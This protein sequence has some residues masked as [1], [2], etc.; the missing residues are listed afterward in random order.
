MVLLL[1]LLGR[2]GPFSIDMYLPG[3]PSIAGDFS[4]A[5]ADVQ[6]SL[7][8]FLVGF[9][10]APLIYGPLS[11]RFGRRPI[12]ITA[13]TVYFLSTVCCALTSTMDNFLA[14]RVLQGIGAGAGPV[15]SRAIVRDLYGP[16]HSAR[17]LSLIQAIVVMGPIIAPIIGGYLLVWFG[18]RSIFWL[19]VIYGVLCL[20]TMILCINET[21]SH[22]ST[23]GI[24]HAFRGYAHVLRDKRYV[25]YV[26][27]SGFA[28]GGLFAFVTGSPFV[29]IELF[30]VAPQHFGFLFGISAIAL[31]VG[32]ALNSQLV[33][34]LGFHRMLVIG[35]SI[36]AFAGVLIYTVARFELGGL[37]G[38]FI[39]ICCALA[40]VT[41]IAPNAAVGAMENHPARAGAASAL[42]SALQFGFGALGGWLVGWLH[43][44]SAMPLATVMLTAGMLS[45]AAQRWLLR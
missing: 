24:A 12:L 18:W 7:S 23:L 42:L 27:T 8:T 2:L 39:P 45:F 22:R 14:L 25:G 21:N 30:G 43:D 37:F 36:T 9:G 26:L 29:I 15:L 20:T 1:S 33:T 28:F 32:A 31:S 5:T 4:V 38:L 35:S 13:L 3:L 41:L 16:T 10:I 11:D 6:H 40:A 44:G 17:V 19:L 34:R